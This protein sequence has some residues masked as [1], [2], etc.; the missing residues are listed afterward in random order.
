MLGVLAIA[1]A[2]ALPRSAGAA[3]PATLS[4][5]VQSG[6]TTSTRPLANA[7][8][9]LYEATAAAP[10][11]LGQATTSATGAFAIASPTDTTPGV[12]YVSTAIDRGV[13]LVA[14]LGGSLPSA[15]TVNELTTVAAGY[16]MAQFYENG[17]IS[18]DPFA[19]ELAAGMNENVVDTA[20][21][22][23]SPVLLASPNADETNSLRLTLSLANLVAAS[24]TDRGVAASLLAL[25]KP[26]R[27]PL[28]GTTPQALA[29]LA[30]DPAKHADQIYRLTTRSRAYEPPLQRTPDAWT[31]VVKVNDSGSDDQDALF[32]GPGNLAFDDRG[33]AWV[34]NNVLQGD[35]PSSSYVAVL[36]PNGKPSDG[37]TGTPLSPLAG[38]GI[39]GT[40]FG[41]TIDATGTIW[42]GNFGWGG[43]DFYPDPGESISRFS[44]AG[45]PLSGNGEGGE[46]D[47]AQGMVADDDGNVWVASYGN[48][49]V[50][51]FP[52]G[53][54]TRAVSLE[55]YL[56]SQPFDVAIAPDGAAWV[57][58]S[59]GLLG[60][61][62][63][64]VA[65]F[66]FEAGILRRH[67]LRPLG[68]ALKGLAVDSHGRV[69]VASLGEDAVYGL[70]PD[71]TVFGRFAGGGI[72]GP[73]DVTID[74]DENLWISNFGQ[75][76]ATNIFP[77]GRLSK[78]CGSEPS[79]CPPGKKAGDPISPATGYPT[80]SAG[81]QVLLHNGDPLY[82]PGAP[83]SFA[84]M[85]R[86]TSSVIDQAGNVW[87]IN[88]YK[89]DFTVDAV[90]NPGG[91]GILI[92][93][94]L[95][96]PP[97]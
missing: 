2:V 96:P 4:G 63:S 7:R 26:A 15:T 11:V 8:V 93:V 90:A 70:R 16:S 1:A 88:N 71:G 59:G 35:T 39:L 83:P 85:T 80:P 94:G 47:R 87:T 6:G 68:S 61:Y 57:S 28:P 77:H 66:T 25:T 69:W 18:G 81:S 58:N 82:G 65:R 32:G 75:I 37:T 46:V 33:Y 17:A 38:S 42:Y 30:R 49:S 20:T 56:G 13:E 62:P 79:A 76:T 48:D 55:Q 53:D 73:W 89:P 27:G 54:V 3:A 86:Q 60:G 45:A 40:G 97:G 43:K 29:N 23:S 50:F 67:L 22:D 78:L 72:L 74:G 12:F 19:L 36:Q 51:V 9:T 91:D 31:V 64:S 95:A 84:P 14:V 5:V 10:K 92:Y 41:V 24:V 21:G 52:G 34:T 44:P